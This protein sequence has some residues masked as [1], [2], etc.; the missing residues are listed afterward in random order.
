MKQR[1]NPRSPVF[2]LA[3]TIATIAGLIFAAPDA[4]SVVASGVTWGA[5]NTPGTVNA[6]A[7][8]PVQ[9]DF[10]NSGTVPWLAGGVNPVR[11]SYHWKNG[12]CPGS[13]TAVW[14]GGRANLP[15]NTNP[16]MAVSDL[17]LNVRAPGTP[18]SY[19]L[20][21]DLVQE[22]ISWFSTLGAATKDVSVNVVASMY[23]VTWGAH[24]T[25]GTMPPGGISNVSI[26]F[27]NSSSVAWLSGGSNPVRLSYHWKT[28]A[29]PGSTTAV[30]DGRRAT[31][32]GNVAP[33]A[34]VSGLQLGVQTPGAAGTYCLVYDLVQEGVSWFSTMTAS[35]LATTVNV[36]SAT[37]AYA[38]TWGSTNTAA[39]M[40]AASTTSFN[41]SFTNSGPGTWDSGGANPVRLSYHWKNGTCPG[42][43]TAVWDG[44]RGILPA[45]VPAGG[46]VNSLAI[47]VLSPSAGGTYC[48]TYD[49]VEEGVTWFSTQGALTL[50]RTVTISGG[51]SPTATPS[52]TSASSATSTPGPTATPS[53]PG[54]W[55]FQ[56]T[57]TGTPSSP[58]PFLSNRFD[59]IVG[60]NN[61]DAI[62]TGFNFDDPNDDGK[63]QTGHGSGC[64]APPAQH[65]I[66]PAS[67]P[68]AF[69][70]VTRPQLMFLC[71]DH[72]MTVMK[73][74]Y[75]IISFMPRQLFDWNG[76]TG[77]VEIDT[78]IYA[79]AREWWDFY[80]VPE[81]E[82]LLEI[83]T[84]DEGATSE[85][86]PKRGV[87]FSMLDSQPH[88]QVIDN[89]DVISE[90]GLPGFS[91]AFANDPA[92]TDPAKRRTFRLKMSNTS[93][94]ISIQK[95]DG[96]FYTYSANFPQPLSFSR[97]LVR[98]EQHAYN[99]RK[100]GIEDPYFTY[101]W[102]NFRFDGP[103]LPSRLTFE[104]A[105]HFVDMRNASVGEVSVPITI[106]VTS[107]SQA[108]LI[109]HLHSD[110]FYLPE[111]ITN[112]EHWG[113]VRVNNGA[114]VDIKFR[115]AVAYNDN[116]GWTTIDTPISGL[117]N[118]ANTIQFKYNTRPSGLT[119]QADG[120]RIKDLEIQ[121]AGSHPM[122]Y[123]ASEF[124][125]IFAVAGTRQ[126]ICEV[127]TNSGFHTLPG[128]PTPIG[129]GEPDSDTARGFAVTS[130]PDLERHSGFAVSYVSATKRPAWP[131]YV[132]FARWPF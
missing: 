30:W 2:K 98:V 43:T 35:T 27:T 25:P 72:M 9:I 32:A 83:A 123:Q 19:C 28:G 8:F 23:V 15:G 38:V 48:L 41:V 12:A 87:K 53:P 120:F 31:L 77:T 105:P 1:T 56:E 45:N 100:D 14:D 20:V 131:A 118:G 33:G 96:S 61:S 17:T 91:T 59:V 121:V 114:W 113:Q 16:G 13:T 69:Q 79:Y 58:A 11:L 75:G 122:A 89:Y 85:G 126:L 37:G 68:Q 42:S 67:Q 115:K 29:C 57:F 78:N 103:V 64:E 40:A 5:H 125:P 60:E 21:Y 117:V 104:A 63:I 10:T 86:L 44:K 18:G 4:S 26:S 82:M 71:K 65:I 7:T 110:A 22:G 99:P 76:R 49:L 92:R 6:G 39:S 47:S 124:T 54:N 109:G 116:R 127:G 51:T 108:R 129:N 128:W 36:T 102:D 101:H 119:W 88:I 111:K 130:S 106:N 24:N 74:G 73:S 70:T 112:S 94:T 90:Q 80:I 3:I 66:I 97:G 93:W 107:T 52:P 95:Q 55:A 34:S 46:A 84:R 132:S 50:N 62:I 81:D